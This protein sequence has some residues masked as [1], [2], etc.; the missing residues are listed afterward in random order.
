MRG[1]I[2]Q[3]N[4]NEG[5]GVIVADGTQYGFKIASWKGD[6]IPAVGK[7]VDLSVAEGQ[8]LTVMVVPEDIILREKTAELGGKLGAIVG[9]IGSS[10]AKAGAGSSGGSIVTFYGRALLVSYGVFLLGTLFLDAISISFF[11]ASQGQPLWDLATLLGQFGVV[12][13]IKVGL[14]LSYVGFAVPYFW[15]DRR[16]WLILALPL[17]VVLYSL[18][19][20][21]R[22]IGGGPGGGASDLFSLGIG[23]YLSLAS[24][25]VLAAGGVK[26][27][28]AGS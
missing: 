20:A 28:L 26:R 19:S 11:G 17:L 4:G 16:G 27:F 24:G 22:A 3:Y 13:G 12:K 9:D 5:Q 8:V 14:I 15:R 23:A 6:S 1:K 10:L 25:A 7:A 18:W 2:L 21:S